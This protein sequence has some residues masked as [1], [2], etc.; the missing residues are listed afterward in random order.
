MEFHDKYKKDMIEI[1]DSFEE[2]IKE[3]DIQLR[4]YKDHKEE[5]KKEYDN[6]FVAVQNK[7]VIGYDKNYDALKR[8]IES[9]SIDKIVLILSLQTNI[10]A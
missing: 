1:I 7:A 4:W 5:I 3:R 8:R 9:K 10:F 2:F 6:G